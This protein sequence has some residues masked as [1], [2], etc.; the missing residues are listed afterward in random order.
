MR[1]TLIPIAALLTVV[2]AAVAAPAAIPD[3]NG[4]IHACRNTKT[5][6]LR[7]IDTDKGQT[8]RK[9]EVALTWN[10]SGPQGPAGPSGVSGYH[11]VHQQT[12]LA[13]TAGPDGWA[14][15]NAEVRCPAGEKVINGG[16]YAFIGDQQGV[17]AMIADSEPFDSESSGS[18]WVM[19]F[20][21]QYRVDAQWYANLT[22][23]CAVVS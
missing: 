10:Q 21:T 19:H 9:G 12:A 23:T 17:L 11:Q 5:G 2:A 8:C 16:G 13:W 14:R 7:V 6:V 18:G 20:R 1:K 15:S 22:A 3:A 4:S